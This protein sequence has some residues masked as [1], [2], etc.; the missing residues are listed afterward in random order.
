MPANEYAAGGSQIR[1]ANETP[2]GPGAPRALAPLTLCIGAGL[3]LAFT[4]VL[5]WHLKTGDWVCLSDWFGLYYLRF[6]AQAY[7]NHTLYIGD[8]VVPGGATTYPWL[9][10]V[11]ATF[12]A[13]AFGAG[14]FA[15]NLI[16]TL[17]SAIGLSAG[18]YFVFRHF[19]KRSWVAAGCTMLCFSDYGF[20]AARPFTTQLQ[21]LASALWFRPRGL[22]VIPW[23]LL[24]QWRIP[25]PGLN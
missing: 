24:L 5:V 21:I 7:Y 19:L 4:P 20:A 22:V 11:P 12:V 23:G 6:A 15:V 10:F 14:P 16:W 2:P 17:L 3:V 9:Q 13:R 1:S 18:L 25:D 8:I